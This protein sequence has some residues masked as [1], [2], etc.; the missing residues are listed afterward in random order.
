MNKFQERGASLAVLTEYASRLS[1]QLVVI[2]ELRVMLL[3]RRPD[4]DTLLMKFHQFHAQ[5]AELHDVNPVADKALDAIELAVLDSLALPEL[6]EAL[7]RSG[8]LGGSDL[9]RLYENY[10]RA[11]L[12][13][14]ESVRFD[15][16]RVTDGMAYL[17][18]LPSPGRAGLNE[19]IK[20][21]A[22][23][24]DTPNLDRFNMRNVVV[25]LSLAVAT[26]GAMPEDAKRDG[27]GARVFVVAMIDLLREYVQDSRLRVEIYVQM[28][29]HLNN[30]S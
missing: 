9:Y 13:W 16:K 19:L 3:A 30:A 25:L 22:E 29:S 14:P 26:L 1:S 10:T 15:D 18:D 21:L 11:F 27:S 2:E 28:A 5:A 8:H 20:A 6:A 12:N 23:L 4:T 7:V 24:R 17:R